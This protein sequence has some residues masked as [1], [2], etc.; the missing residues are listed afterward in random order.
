[1]H[2]LL[3]GFKRVGWTNANLKAII[4]KYI[5]S[6]F[7]IGENSKRKNNTILHLKYNFYGSKQIV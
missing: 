6:N 2:M 3:L 5:L 7:V 4:W 1:M